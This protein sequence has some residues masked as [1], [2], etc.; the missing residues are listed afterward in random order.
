MITV[1]TF[2]AAW[3]AIDLSPFVVKALTWLRM[4]GIEHRTAPGDIRKAP[5]RKLPYIDDGGRLLGDSSLIIEHIQAK[6]PEARLP[7]D[8]L[9]PAQTAVATAFKGMIES[10]LYFVI[11]YARWVEDAGFALYRP[12]LR[13]S[14]R[15]MGLPSFATLPV[16]FVLR[17]QMIS[18]TYEQGMGRHSFSVV[19]AKARTHIDAMAAH[20]GE[21]P[22]FMGDEPGTI[23]ATVFAFV[24]GLANNPLSP[25]L[26]DHLRRHPNLLAYRARM[27]A[28]YWPD[29]AAS[30]ASPK[31]PR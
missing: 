12:V 20:L 9:S 16:L 15:K 3:D 28:R 27:L 1:H 19:V 7:G 21:K 5:Q 17:R 10:E 6:T 31:A 24:D 26:T 23:D 14:L 25:L 4:T 29:V 11:L 30:P 13:G 8:A 22:Y 2:G 18:Q